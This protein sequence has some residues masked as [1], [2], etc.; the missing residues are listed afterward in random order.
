[1]S[2]PNEEIQAKKF[3]WAYMLQVGRITN[4]NW[5]YYGA[6][7]DYGEK[8]DPPMEALRKKAKTSAIDWDKTK[9]P[10]AEEQS[11]F[12]GTF[13]EA[14]RVETLLGTIYFKDGSGYRVG[15]GKAE[16]RFKDYMESLRSILDDKKRITLMFGE[17]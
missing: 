7:W 17:E 8:T 1:M 12:Q 10:K 6:G 3:V 4:G 16:S 15:V 9:F 2:I 11:S 14:S 5:S 13:A